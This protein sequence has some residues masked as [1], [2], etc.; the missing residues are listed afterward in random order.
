VAGLQK[1]LAAARL[2]Q[3]VYN[4]DY[5]LGETALNLLGEA[6]VKVRKV[7]IAAGPF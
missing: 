5:P 1:W 7:S 2:E 3:V 6:G 4:T